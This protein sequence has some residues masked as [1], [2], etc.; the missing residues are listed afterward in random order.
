MFNC[1]IPNYTCEP[2]LAVKQGNPV[3][4]WEALFRE[5][6]S[7]DETWL[8][9]DRK[10]F[11]YL[12]NNQPGDSLKQK[13]IAVNL[14]TDSVLGMTDEFIKVVASKWKICIEWTEDFASRRDIQGASEQH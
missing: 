8:E 9:V 11:E 3:L 1:S 5:Q 7:S 13:A 2:I 10:L 14:S 6:R 12:A 4:F